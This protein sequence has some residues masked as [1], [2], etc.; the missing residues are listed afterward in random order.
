MLFVAVGR[1]LTIETRSIAIYAVAS[2]PDGLTD[3]LTQGSH[4]R[5]ASY[6]HERQVPKGNE[7]LWVVRNLGQ[8][9]ILTI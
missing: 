8:D 6:G 1:Y 3:R 9:E 4:T 2:M 5:A 7:I